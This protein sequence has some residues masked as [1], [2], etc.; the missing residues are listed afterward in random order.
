MRPRRG[1][2]DPDRLRSGVPL[3]SIN[4]PCLERLITHAQSIIRF[5]LVFTL[6][7]VSL[8]RLYSLSN[9]SVS[10]RPCASFNKLSPTA[11][12]SSSVSK[13]I[14]FLLYSAYPDPYT[15]S[16]ITCNESPSELKPSPSS[17]SAPSSSSMSDSSA[18][19]PPESPAVARSS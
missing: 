13:G 2:D 7:P 16:S 15:S 6:F 10:E 19:S 14:R 5:R 11:T 17:S 18:P 8:Y 3:L 4:F 1:C 12:A 9:S